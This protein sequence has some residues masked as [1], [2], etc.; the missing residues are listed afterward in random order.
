MLSLQRP[1]AAGEQAQA[2]THDTDQRQL[3]SPARLVARDGNG[4]SVVQ[5][6]VAKTES[7]ITLRPKHKPVQPRGAYVRRREYPC[8]C[9]RV[10][11]V[12]EEAQRL[13]TTIHLFQPQQG[14]RT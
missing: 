7:W 4:D 12:R 8:P 1:V 9:P 11:R 14:I 3:H 10:Q 2:T 5:D 6:A 13:I